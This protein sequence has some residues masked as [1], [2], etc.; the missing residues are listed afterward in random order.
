[1]PVVRSGEATVHEIHGARFVSYATPATGSSELCAWRVEIPAGTQGVEH[2]I[3][4][5]EIVHLLAGTPVVTIDGR[6]SR[7]APGDTVI[8]PAGAAL[9]IDNPG[10]E[11]AE[12]WV[13]TSTGLQAVLADGSVITPPWAS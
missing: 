8:A 4:R 10:E 3:S 5:E 7:L 1:M 12:A 9:K 11:T 6:P 2:T 13:T